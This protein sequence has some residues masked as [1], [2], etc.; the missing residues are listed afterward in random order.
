MD[1]E[2]YKDFRLQSKWFSR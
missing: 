1:F 2:D